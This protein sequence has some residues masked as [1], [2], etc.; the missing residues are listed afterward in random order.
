MFVQT[1]HK[2]EKM[3]AN[4]PQRINFYSTKHVSNVLDSV[5]RLLIETQDDLASDGVKQ[6]LPRYLQILEICHFSTS[7]LRESIKIDIPEILIN[8]ISNGKS[9]MNQSSDSSPYQL[10]QR[11]FAQCLKQQNLVIRSIDIPKFAKWISTCLENKS[12]TAG[13]LQPTFEILESAF[14][15]VA[16]SEIILKH[17]YGLVK[18]LIKVTKISKFDLEVLLLNIKVSHGTLNPFAGFQTVYGD[19]KIP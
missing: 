2:I 6:Q 14:Q 12:T 3:Q 5:K 13:E 7:T 8:I 17:N 11:C 10:S 19:P 4:S 18:D 15:S 9:I 16:V 1:C